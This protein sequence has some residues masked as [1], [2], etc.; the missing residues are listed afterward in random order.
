MHILIPYAALPKTGPGAA[1]APPA[2][3]HLSRLLGLLTPVSRTPQG[4]GRLTPLHEQMRAQYLG[5]PSR[6]GLVPW[7]ALDALQQGPQLGIDSATGAWH[8]GHWAWISLC[9]WQVN[10]DH[11]HMGDPAALQMSEQE[12]TSLM[13][14]MQ[15]YFAE[16]GIALHHLRPGTWLA[17]GAVFAELATASLDLVRGQSVDAWMPRQAQAHV[18]RRLQNEMQMLLYTHPFNQA[19]SAQGLAEINSFWISGTGALPAD[20]RPVAE[21]VQVFDNLRSAALAQDAGAWVQAWQ[22]L[23]AGPLATLAAQLANGTY[24]HAALSLS[25]CA[26]HAAQTFTLQPRSFWRKLRQRIAPLNA[27]TYATTWLQ[28]L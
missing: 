20:Y 17:Q 11:V 12:S 10:A 2:L 1:A 3:P 19:R 13:A 8:R 23:D 9:H 4:D 16:D 22:A 15:A 27:Q 7:A 26:S 25:L 28:T 14:T 18:L 21:S 24:A 6:D 5:L